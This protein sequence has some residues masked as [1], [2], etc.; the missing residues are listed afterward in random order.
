MM[1]F[2]KGN[3]FLM[4]TFFIILVV[5][6]F[7]ICLMIYAQFGKKKKERLFRQ[8][9]KNEYGSVQYKEY[10]YERSQSLTGYFDKHVN[11]DFLIDDISWNDIDGERLFRR[12][13]YCNSSV[14]EEYLY[15]RLRHLRFQMS[16]EEMESFEKRISSIDVNEEERLNIQLLFAKLGRC[17]KY[18]I[19]RYL[20]WLSSVKK[21]SVLFYWLF[22]LIYP[23]CFILMYFEPSLG[24]LSIALVLAVRILLHVKER[25]EIEPYIVSLSYM[26]RTFQFVDR[27][28]KNKTIQEI[29]PEESK[30]LKVLR[31]EIKGISSFYMLFLTDSGD[32]LWDGLMIY[33]NSLTGF[34]II[35]FYGMLD[36]VDK[37]KAQ[38]DEMISLLGRME[39]EISIA[40]FRKSLP[41]YC[42][43]DFTKSVSVSM[44]EVFHPMLEQPVANSFSIEKGMLLTG[45]NASGK[46]TFLKTVEISA[47]LAQTIQTVPAQSYKAP[48]FRIFSSMSLRDSLESSESYYIVEIKAMKRIFDANVKTDV[49]LLCFVDEV[50]RGTNT[51]E[52]ISASA[53]ILSEF[54][55]SGIFAF[56]ATHDLELT[57]ILSDIYENYHFEELVSN[58]DVT[59][60][61]KLLKGPAETRNA[62]KLLRLMGYPEQIIEKAERRA[63]ALMTK[64]V[65][66][67]GNINEG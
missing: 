51:I 31:K 50:L 26:I 11:K 47:I 9:L 63:V 12:L 60:P 55:R 18:S 45:S 10:S 37:Y 62:I 66:E 5:L 3:C 23:I 1:T 59:F 48:F 67:N 54:S 4:K 44:E 39:S 41:Y 58:D 15:Y 16:E 14:G 33:L 56:A 65:K 27:I 24:V 21:R 42:V 40:S 22:L 61:Y 2:L 7:Y 20:D 36:K 53:E 35:A 64:K 52:R 46:S 57:Q 34:D 13:N 30:R 6:F 25:K 8:R 32:S 28:S 49:P 43:P 38:M 29:W 19:F 17:G